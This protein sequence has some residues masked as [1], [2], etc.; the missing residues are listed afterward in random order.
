MSVYL[1]SKLLLRQVLLKIMEH[2][3][4]FLNVMF[5]VFLFFLCWDPGG[6]EI[7][8]YLMPKHFWP[9]SGRHQF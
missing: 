7:V 9:Y 2:C 6:K 3:L 1:G 4:L 8:P 5:Q